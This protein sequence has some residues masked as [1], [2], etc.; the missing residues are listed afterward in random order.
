MT[1]G[2][3]ETETIMTEVVMKLG[4]QLPV[5]THEVVK[6]GIAKA[7]LRGRNDEQCRKEQ[8]LDCRGVEAGGIGKADA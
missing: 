1:D 3:Q 2:I 7:Y 4:G 6:K 8:P 5:L